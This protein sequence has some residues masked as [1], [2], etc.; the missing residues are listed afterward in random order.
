MPVDKV[1]LVKIIEGCCKGEIGIITRVLNLS[2]E[3]VLVQ[4]CSNRNK[5][6]ELS[7]CMVEPIS[8]TAGDMVTIVNKY[9][10]NNENE[11]YV[12]VHINDNDY[13]VI[14]NKS[15]DVLTVPKSC[16][17]PVKKHNYEDTSSAVQDEVRKI[18]DEL[19]D[20]IYDNIEWDTIAMGAEEW[21]KQVNKCGVADYV[22]G[23]MESLY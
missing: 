20:E 1:E 11:E 3:R 6:L 19:Y 22:A 17:V 2:P 14:V 16:L 9:S 10:K 7:K 18:L 4:L 12:L 15:L 23:I 21:T 8:I 13:A 5:F